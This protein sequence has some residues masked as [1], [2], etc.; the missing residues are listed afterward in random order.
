MNQ[1]LELL[2]PVGR[3]VWGSLITPITKDAMGNPLTFKTGAKLGQPRSD[4]KFAIAIP[5]NGTTHWT[6]TEWG[7]KI[8]AF[9]QQQFISGELNSPKFAWK[10]VD[11][12]STQANDK[13]RRLCDRPGY[14]GNWVVTFSRTLAPELVNTKGQQILDLNTVNLGDYIQVFG[15][16]VCNKSINPS[17]IFNHRYVAFIGHGERI[18][19][20]KQAD[21][22]DW[23]EE[24]STVPQSN[25]NPALTTQP[26]PQLNMQTPTV[27]TPVIQ[28]YTQILQT[29]APAA[30]P[31]PPQ[32]VK[33]MTPKANGATYEQFIASGWNDQQLIQHGYLEI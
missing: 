19:L 21:E 15:E 30:P 27:A 31:T 7:I 9:A 10:I 22:I 25:F 16:L 13:G 14:A 3:F 17:L 33:R 8:Y 2:T 1:R 5:K 11:G 23:S 24:M 18:V 20:G 32:P 4:Y 6:Q 12:D 28:P 26:Y 29:P